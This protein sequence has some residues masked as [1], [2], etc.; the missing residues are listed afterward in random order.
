MKNDYKALCHFT[1]ERVMIT[2]TKLIKGEQLS[3]LYQLHMA[4]LVTKA[5]EIMSERY[6]DMAPEELLVIA[7]VGFLVEDDE[8]P[9]GPVRQEML[10][11]SLDYLKSNYGDEEAEIK[12]SADDWN[13]C[14]DLASVLRKLLPLK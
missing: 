5:I 9:M 1:Q 13:R 8:V 14:E 7:L 11:V 6:P 12:I 2:T 10:D 4:A 3:D